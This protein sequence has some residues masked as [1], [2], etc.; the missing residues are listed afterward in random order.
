M[1]DISILIEKAR[2]A[3]K[4]WAKFSYSERAKCIKKVGR[5]LN[6][7]RDEIIEIIQRENGKLA[8]D[9]LASELVPAFMAVPYYIKKGKHLCMPHKLGGGNLLMFFKTSTMT[10]EPW[11]VVGIISPW[12][13]PFS[14]PFSEV[15]MALLAGNAVILKTATLTPGAGRV[16]SEILEAA[17]LPQ[18]LF[19]NVE[20]PGNEA[21]AAFIGGGIDKL[22]FTGSTAVGKK[23]MA[24]AA[25][26]LLPMT[27]ELGG[28][29]AAI[30][31]K[32][33]DINRA[34]S[35]IIWGAFS[36]AGQ[37]CGGVQRVFVHKDKYDKFIEIIK[38]KVEAL[39]PGNEISCDLSR[40]ISI[41]GKEEVCKQ[42]KECLAKGAEIAAQSKAFTA[43][44]GKAAGSLDDESLFVPVI[45]LTG[46]K[47]GMPI[48]DDEIFGPVIGVLP[49]NDDEQAIALANASPYALNGSVWTRNKKQA[50]KLAALI[51][52]GSVMIN[53]HLMSHGLA[54]AV[55]GGYGASGIG[56]THGELGFRE[57]LKTKVIIGDILPGAKRQP[58]W[59]PYSQKLYKGLLAL[60][61]VLSAPLF[62]KIAAL[63][64]LIKFFLLAWSKNGDKS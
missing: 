27:L 6:E 64:A 50:K 2:Q 4:Q 52:A 14:I 33:A 21:G 42:V 40:L 48:F 59:Q 38:E 57:M 8:V 46:I 28:A 1:Q 36:N 31:C 34:V 17:N 51:H 62:K 41:R 39:R 22:F 26:R 55:W 7:K 12:N 53:D 44:D 25:E 10:Y 5:S 60:G 61:D 23:L 18:G 37:S 30:V 9:A 47:A 15:I 56:K 45:V 54:Q 49:F 19:V 43:P 35:G 29:D 24:Q 63:P 58:W 13:Y 3:Q 11:G 32:D 16:I 20:I